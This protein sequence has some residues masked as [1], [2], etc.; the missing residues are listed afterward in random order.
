MTQRRFHKINFALVK[1]HVP[2]LADLT[3]TQLMDAVYRHKET[4]PADDY[5]PPNLYHILPYLPSDEANPLNQESDIMENGHAVDVLTHDR[6]VQHEQRV[7]A[8]RLRR[9]RRRS[10]TLRFMMGGEPLSAKELRSLFVSILRAAYAKQIKEGELVAR[11]F[12][13]VAL[14]QSLEF[15]TD[16]VGN[17][18]TLRDW[19]YVTMFDRP[20]TDAALGLKNSA[21]AFGCLQQAWATRAH[22]GFRLTARRLKVE[23]SL[24]FMDAH[25]WAQEYFQK[26]FQDAESEL[27]EAGKIVL[28]ESRA[29]YR[30]AEECLNKTPA[31]ELQ[32]AVSH[33]FC[34]ILLSGGIS[35]VD[36]LVEIGLLKESEA[37]H[38]VEEIERH[39]DMVMSCEETDH[40]GEIDLQVDEQGDSS[41]SDDDT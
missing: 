22:T 5:H 38:L 3:R 11:H 29:Q 32:I 36:H 15:A 20:I 27:S 37:E 28:E 14:E 30:N 6:R 23:R 40:P 9:H 31:K 4:T 24:A 12:L 41:D 33:K 39:L 26:E 21:A 18:E 1:H 35:Y 25:R 34:T 19:E 8:R 7:K 17:G 13:T 16:A 2:E 10:S